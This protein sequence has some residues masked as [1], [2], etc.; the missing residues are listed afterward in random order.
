MLGV[1]LGQNIQTHWH[2]FSL[3]V[4]TETAVLDQ[5]DPAVPGERNTQ[6]DR[7]VDRLVD[8]QTDRWTDSSVSVVV[9]VTRLSVH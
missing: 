7:L 3:V 6:T 8:R 9:F 5:E 4:T 1:S 2:L